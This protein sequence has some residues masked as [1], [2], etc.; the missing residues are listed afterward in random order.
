M[1]EENRLG[2]YHYFCTRRPFVRPSSLRSLFR[3]NDL[4]RKRLLYLKT[5]AKRLPRDRHTGLVEVRSQLCLLKMVWDTVGL[6]D[7][8]FASWN[9]TLWAEVRVRR[10]WHLNI[11]DCIGYCNMLS[12]ESS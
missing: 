3:A 8:L 4:D 5:Y 10:E 12:N 6:V 1:I 11:V 7:G 9:T 2:S